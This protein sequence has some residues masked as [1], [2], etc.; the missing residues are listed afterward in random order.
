MC[1]AANCALLE[2]HKKRASCKF[3]VKLYVKSHTLTA[4]VIFYHR[5]IHLGC[6]CF[7]VWINVCSLC[8]VNNDAFGMLDS[9][10]DTDPYF[11]V[12][13]NQIS[14]IVNHC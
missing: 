12:F 1:A 14:K 2:I 6:Q 4:C 7:L 10:G 9:R 13:R 8:N 3:H 11:F 5:D